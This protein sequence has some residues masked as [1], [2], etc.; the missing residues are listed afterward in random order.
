MIQFSL[1]YVNAK[2]DVKI[3]RSRYCSE[4]VVTA[5]VEH[6]RTDVVKVGQN[7]LLSDVVYQF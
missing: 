3:R 7:K 2:L 1:R 5:H 4:L 6:T